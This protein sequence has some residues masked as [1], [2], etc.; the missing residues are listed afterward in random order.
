MVDAPTDVIL[1]VAENSDRRTG[2]AWYAVQCVPRKEDLAATVLEHHRGVHSYV[3]KVLRRRHGGS[4]M[5]IFFT[6]YIFVRTDLNVVQLSRINSTPGVLRILGSSDR[7]LPVAEEVVLGIRKRL[8]EMNGSGGLRTHNFKAGETV[9][10]KSGP[11]Q[12]LE[13]AFIGPTSAGTRV[14]ILLD[15]LGRPNE[16]KV[17]AEDLE[18]VSPMDAPKLER[19]TRGRGRRINS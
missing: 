4:E 1:D 17:E 12:G 2:D 3:P 5:V 15:F 7:P 14:K 13:A 6:G 11:L 18:P 10:V 9:R 19:R 8:D 16:V